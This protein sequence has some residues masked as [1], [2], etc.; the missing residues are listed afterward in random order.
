VISWDTSCVLKLYTAE[1]D[2][3]AW[4]NQALVTDDDFVASALLETE[5]A[6][7]LAQKEL[8][9]EVKPGGAQALLRLF[10]RDVQAGRFALYPVGA[11]IMLAAV[12]IAAKCYRAERPIPLRTLDGL[13]LAT[14]KVLKCRA[15]ATVDQ[16]M[17]AAA[18]L[19]HLPLF[20][21]SPRI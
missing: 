12:D 20:R 16:R 2:S 18:A 11:D 1:S 19:L 6:Y 10:G 14:A 4:Q 9:G 8:R 17:Q 13:H 15:L 21:S 7:A 5:M 3:L